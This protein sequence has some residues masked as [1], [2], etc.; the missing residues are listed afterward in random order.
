[1]RRLLVFGLSGQVGDAL[2]PALAERG[3]KVFAVSRQLRDAPAGI[4]WLR[5]S[6]QDMPELPA[7]LDAIVS[8][9]PLDAF[10]AWFA[11]RGPGVARIVALGSTG[12]VDKLHSPDPLERE[13]AQRLASAED[14]LS[15]ACAR[16]GVGLTLLRPTMV[17]GADRDRSLSR[18]LQVARRWHVLV[19]PSDARGLR[20]PVHVADVA[21][22]V[23]KC[24]ETPATAGLAFDLPGGEAIAFDQM[25]RRTLAARAP[26]CRL[27][28]IPTPL[29][30]LG[31]AIV[32]RV[33]PAPL[34]PGMLARL[35]M[36]QLADDSAARSAFGY[37]PRRFD[38]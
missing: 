29:F 12:R 15:A 37:R 22:A 20:Q 30:R 13:L 21:W 16:R 27:I 38:P 18:L 24:L 36:D 14:T 19:L 35:S 11:E 5:G 7:G 3:D 1:M 8:L 26:A 32:S 2:L 31:L 17:Y 28:R 9:G 25:V 23:Q 4:D 33:R 10:A 34:G 6:L